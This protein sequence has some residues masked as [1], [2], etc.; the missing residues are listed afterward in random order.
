M[1][2]EQELQQIARDLANGSCFSDWAISN[3][4]DVSLIFQAINFMTDEQLNGLKAEDI[5]MIYEYKSEAAYYEGDVPIFV[6]FHC[7][8]K[9]DAI[10]VGEMFNHYHKILHENKEIEI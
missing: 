2:T 5:G 8:S 7:L 10:K 3:N 4:A 9:E 6:S 1:R